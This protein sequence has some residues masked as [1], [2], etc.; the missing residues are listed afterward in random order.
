V[1]T[2]ASEELQSNI[3]KAN[4]EYDAAVEKGNPTA[5]KSAQRSLQLAI[6]EKKNMTA[7]LK[8]A[9]SQIGEEEQKLKA[10]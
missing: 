10:I 5:I 6:D 3:D 8:E 4:E 9:K 2:A 1:Y 7:K